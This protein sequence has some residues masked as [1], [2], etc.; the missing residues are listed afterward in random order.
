MQLQVCVVCTCIL[1]SQMWVLCWLL[2]AMVGHYVPE[3]DEKWKNFSLLIKIMSY[4]FSPII[5]SGECA[6]L[7]VNIHLPR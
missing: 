4:C 6:Y 3:D 7:K 5:T 1:A 2:P